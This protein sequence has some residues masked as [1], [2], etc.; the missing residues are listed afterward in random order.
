M[1]VVVPQTVASEAGVGAVVAAVAA[2]GLRYITGGSP[3]M[4]NDI[5]LQELV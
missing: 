2:W 3:W 5:V 1:Y 4:L